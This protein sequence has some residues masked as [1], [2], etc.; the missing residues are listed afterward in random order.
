[1]TV[2]FT[3]RKKSALFDE[4][5]GAH[6]EDNKAL[7]Q[8]CGLDCFRCEIYK[9]KKQVI[10][11]NG[12]IGCWVSEMGRFLAKVADNRIGNTSISRHVNVQ[13]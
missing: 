5:K 11:P 10:V 1:M 2:I 13:H 12:F 6:M 7:M 3:Y 9:D 8:L 4:L